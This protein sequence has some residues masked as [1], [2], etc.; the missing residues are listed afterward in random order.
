MFSDLVAPLYGPGD[1]STTSQIVFDGKLVSVTFFQ[2]WL[3]RRECVSCVN[4]S[5]LEEQNL[6]YV[7]VAESDLVLNFSITR[8][9][10]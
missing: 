4:K 6:R 1:S 9:E 5:R 2:G 10:A 3:A 8:A 7:V